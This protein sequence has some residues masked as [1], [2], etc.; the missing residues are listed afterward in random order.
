MAWLYRKFLAALS[1][2]CVLIKRYHKMNIIKRAEIVNLSISAA[3]A[4]V[5]VIFLES[6]MNMR[7]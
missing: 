2:G 3:A 7:I 1:L 6:L 4:K 5:I